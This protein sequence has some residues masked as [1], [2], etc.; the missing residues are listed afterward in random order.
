MPRTAGRLGSRRGHCTRK[1]GN[2]GEEGPQFKTNAI[3]SEDLEIGT[4]Q[5]M[6]FRNCRRVAREAKQKP[7]I[8][9]TLYDKISREDPG[10]AYAQCRSTRRTGVDGQD[11]TDVEAY[12]CNGACE[13]A[14]ALR[15]PI[16]RL[17]PIADTDRFE[18]F[19]WSNEGR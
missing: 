7:A 11:F 13:L 17:R 4:Y 9:S 6:V 16:A 8:A 10:P 18:L 2:S 5:S 15:D 12:G 1:P 14:L 3:R 19:Y